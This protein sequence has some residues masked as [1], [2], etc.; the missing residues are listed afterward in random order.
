[1]S[2]SLRP[3]AESLRTRFEQ[4]ESAADAH[5]VY[6]EISGEARQ[7]SLTRHQQRIS[8]LAQLRHQLRTRLNRWIAFWLLVLAVVGCLLWY[9]RPQHDVE[10]PQE[11]ATWLAQQRLL[12]QVAKVQ[13]WLDNGQAESQA[14]PP[15]SFE[16]LQAWLDQIELNP[17]LQST[18]A[19]GGETGEGFVPFQ[20][21]V[22]PVSCPAEFVPAE[23]GDYRFELSRLVRNANIMLADKGDCDGTVD[24]IREYGSLFGWRRS[25]AMTKARTEL[26]VA[27]C[28]L[29][30]GDRDK[31]GLHFQRTF[32]ASVSDPDP[33]Q[34]MSALYGL[35]RL[36]WLDGDDALLRHRTACSEDLLEYHLRE[37]TTVDTLHHYVSLALMHYEF[38]DDTEEAIRLQERALESLRT[39]LAAADAEN[40]NEHHNLMLTLQLN[41]ME[42]YI[43]VGRVET[44]EQMYEDV[45]RNPQLGDADRLI[46]LSMLIMQNLMDRNWP[47]ARS[48][49]AEVIARYTSLAEFTTL[50]SWDAFDRWLDQS[51]S[52]RPDVLD[53]QM[54]DLRTALAPPKSAEA[55][56]TLLRLQQWLAD[57]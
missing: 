30:E 13:Q 38:L 4:A 36:A 29:A 17:E 24:L 27:R 14:P 12:E 31:A 16:E 55:M 6:R 56:N 9:Y 43:T 5:H 23:A 54:R 48:N 3:A 7:R 1:M 10:T 35:A 47:M 46:A 39:L 11:L 33:D 57:K 18:N 20:C 15:Q 53:Q 51:R 40:R 26:S 8:R 52:E 41:L 19:A 45:N 21:Q 32:C 25:E 42:S 37:R 2:K 22:A 28:Y 49:V 50:W 44:M 34:A